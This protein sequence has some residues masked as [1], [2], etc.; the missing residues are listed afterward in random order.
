MTWHIVINVL[1]KICHLCSPMRILSPR[2]LVFTS[3]LV[4]GSK[5]NI[6]TCLQ[7]I[8]TLLLASEEVES[9]QAGGTRGMTGNEAVDVWGLYDVW[10]LIH[11]DSCCFMKSYGWYFMLFFLRFDGLQSRHQSILDA[12]LSHPVKEKPRNDHIQL[13]FMK[14]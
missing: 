13:A 10:G 11:V 2:H 1:K 8:P 5:A 6:A 14:L 3:S 12:L 4:E 9:L 7:V